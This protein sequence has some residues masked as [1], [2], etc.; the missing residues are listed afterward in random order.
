MDLAQAIDLFLLFKRGEGLTQRTVDFYADKLRQFHQFWGD[1]SVGAVPPH[2]IV[3]WLVYQQE[4]GLSPMTIEGS[5]RALLCFFNWCEASPDVGE[6]ASPIGHGQRK[7]VKRPKVDAPQ[8]DFCTYEEYVALTQAIDLAS[9][10]DYRDWCMISVMFWCGVRRGE[11]LAMQVGDVDYAKERIRIRVSKSRRSRSVF[12]VND[13]VA[14]IRQYL[15]LRPRWE[16]EALW[17]AFDKARYGIA[18]ALT[19]TGLRLMLKRRCE[20]AGIRF[21]HPHLF[22]HGFAMAYLNAGVD[23]KAVGDLMG[24]TSYKTTEK[25][26]A[27]WIEEP[28]QRVH[29]LA[30][31]IILGGCD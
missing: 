10:I 18:G 24:H 3:R 25:H 5:Y 13:I 28:L 2:Q 26:Y 14:G 27:R 21:L 11:L 30:A 20:R 9:W 1:G 12:L 19:A 6:P 7:T 23:L 8:M 16:G 31:E 29:K 4:A 15:H 22:R 17:A